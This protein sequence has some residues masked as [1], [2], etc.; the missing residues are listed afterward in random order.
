[1]WWQ[2]CAREPVGG[3]ETVMCDAWLMVSKDFEEELGLS[4]A[5]GFPFV[6]IELS[7]Y[8]LVWQRCVP[9]EAQRLARIEAA[10]FY[11]AKIDAFADP[12][13]GW[14]PDGGLDDDILDASWDG[15]ALDELD[16]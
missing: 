12:D 11:L 2:V 3:E 7:E 15:E 13:G 9:T 14:D 1:M 5:R 8:G 6:T 4:R 10:E 16:A